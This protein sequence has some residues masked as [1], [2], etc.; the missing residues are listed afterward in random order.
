MRNSR[1]GNLDR[2]RVG[3]RNGRNRL[4]GGAQRV[5]RNQRPHVRPQPRRAQPQR[6]SGSRPSGHPAA[7]RRGA[8]RDTSVRRTPAGGTPIRVTNLPFRQLAAAAHALLR[9]LPRWGGRGTGRALVRKARAAAAAAFASVV[10]RPLHAVATVLLVVA[11]LTAT[12]LAQIAPSEPSPELRSPPRWGVLTDGL[13]G[14]ATVQVA[15][16]V[17]GSGNAT[18]VALRD[19]TS[20]VATTGTGAT[21]AGNGAV[22]AAAAAA[23]TPE[24][25][26]QIVPPIL[27]VQPYRVVS[28]DTLSGLA[29]RFGVT[30]D[31]IISFNEIKRARDLRVGREM[32]IPGA[33]GVRYAVRRGDNL[34]RIAIN[35]GVELST[36][37]DVNDIERDLITPGQILVIPGGRLSENAL[38]RVI[39][40][41]FVWPA[42]GR[43]TSRYGYRNDP[44]T[45]I[46]KL[47]NG[48]DVANAQGT[49]IMAAMGGKVATVGYNGNYGRYLIVRHQ[50]GFQTL[51]AH[52]H[53]IV[54]E[55]G[56]SIRQ[57]QRLGGMGNTGYSTANHLHFSIF[58]HGK[59]V[60]PLSLLD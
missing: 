6:P 10:I 56:Q 17:P 33:S 59:H 42:R 8:V 25:A 36:L 13:A 58:H 51:Y 15:A 44:L 32:I 9:G 5:L 54:V 48:I 60:D 30:L 22:T 16:A 55:R 35:H 43:L 47:H 39:G 20:A 52:L 2:Q 49:A 24:P 18:G 37:L 23:P 7:A 40:H 28:G 11:A 31:T 14:R 57:G 53:N 3:R 45:G 34:S 50:D 12:T 41:L 27:Q 26:A 29:A 21:P 46:R 38:N 4:A 1:Y 19:P